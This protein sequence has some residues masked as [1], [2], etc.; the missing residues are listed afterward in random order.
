V[1]IPM[2]PRALNDIVAVYLILAGIISLLH[3]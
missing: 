2:V 1:L 3:I